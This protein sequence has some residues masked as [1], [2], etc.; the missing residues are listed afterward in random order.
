VQIIDIANMIADFTGAAVVPGSK[1]GHDPIAS[2][3]RG[4]IP[5]WLPTIELRDGIRAMVE[6]ARARIKNEKR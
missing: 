6:E 4:R 2:P 1:T 5:G 3:N